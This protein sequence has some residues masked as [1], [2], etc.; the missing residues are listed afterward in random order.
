MDIKKFEEFTFNPD[1]S[2]GW[3]NVKIDD[4]LSD[5]MARYVP[6]LDRI[7]ELTNANP[8]VK[9]D[10]YKKIKV[11]SRI[12]S[13]IDNPTITVQEK[14]SVI[15]I[16]Q[17][18]KEL[19]E[20]FSGSSAGFLM[21]S[22]LAA[23]IHGKKTPGHGKVDITSTNGK[24]D[25]T[26]IFGTEFVTDNDLTYQIKLYKK[27]SSIKIRI[28]PEE[29]MCDYY[30]I[31]IKD[32]ISKKISINI[33]SGK[34]KKDK[35]YIDK[36]EHSVYQRADIEYPNE[37]PKHHRSDDMINFTKPY[38]MIDPSLLIQTSKVELSI[39]TTDI[40]AMIKKCGDSIIKYI[41]IIYGQLSEL[42][43]DIDT[44][45]T[46]INKDIRPVSP[47]DAY[48]KVETTISTISTEMSKLK[49]GIVRKR[50]NSLRI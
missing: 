10:L 12:D 28:L 48:K 29:S 17:Y 11:L 30:V 49:S 39:D 47:D 35:Y 22:F 24:V 33:L 7:L 1:G 34:D 25:K 31:C 4:K 15:T 40:N 46:G 44:L 32:D 38:I 21:E 36:S 5:R 41:K 45:V 13:W 14:I 19:K 23:L 37:W 16:L 43:Y 9:Y 18:L 8:L 50:S 6:A 20:N 2:Q 27:G 26:P 42:H 3:I